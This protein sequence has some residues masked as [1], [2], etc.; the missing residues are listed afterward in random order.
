[1]E[2]GLLQQLSKNMGA[3]LL[4]VEDG[5]F[6]L[7]DHFTRKCENISMNISP[8]EFFYMCDNLQM[9]SNEVMSKFFRKSIEVSVDKFSN[10]PFVIFKSKGKCMFCVNGE[11]TLKENKPI[12]CST[13]PLGRIKRYDVKEKKYVYDTF[14][15]PLPD[16]N[17]K[18]MSVE[19]WFSKNNIKAKDKASDTYT[20]CLCILKTILDFNKLT[21]LDYKDSNLS[22]RDRFN[23]LTSI[24]MILYGNYDYTIKNV[25]LK[26]RI[27]LVIKACKEFVAEH[28]EYK[29]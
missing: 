22:I 5:Q 17:F 28:K 29:K 25:Q 3:E 18:N 11:C 24:V 10:I 16:G 9:N 1:M 14:Q 7:P 19:E 2:K 20:D 15:Y 21:D 27:D 13:Y 6:S 23:V 26:E 4:N 8:L 12:P